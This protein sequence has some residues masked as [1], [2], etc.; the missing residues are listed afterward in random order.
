MRKESTESSVVNNLNFSNKTSRENSIKKMEITTTR[1]VRV[2]DILWHSVSLVAWPAIDMNA[3]LQQTI[4][5][6]RREMVSAETQTE[7]FHCDVIFI[8]ETPEIIL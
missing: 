2:K 6:N 4:V 3:L 1:D 7:I 5:T 8:Q